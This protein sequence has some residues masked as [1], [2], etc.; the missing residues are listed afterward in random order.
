MSSRIVPLGSAS[1]EA[2][3]WRRVEEAPSAAPPHLHQQ[4]K[5]D[6]SDV[7]HPEDNPDHAS[8]QIDPC[9]PLRAS[10]AALEKQLAL[11]QRA[12]DEREKRAVEQGRLE[13][14]AAGV[15]EGAASVQAEAKT[16][17]EAIKAEAA[18]RVAL[19]AGQAVDLR[20][21]LRQQ[22]EADLVKLAI[23]VARRI[24]RRELAVDP[25]ALLGIVKSAV[26]R[27]AARELLAI[28]VA[29]SDAP[30]VRSRLAGYRL[31]ERVE[32]IED[33]A[34]AWG[35]VVLDT[36]RGHHDASVETQIEEIDRG[37]ADLVGRPA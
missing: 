5:P 19:A 7:N 20:K 31:P 14:H 27:I 4:Q 24:L 1:I 34:L 3:P 21:R 10:I 15:R 33:A 6:R 17:I 11:T 28:R 9:E 26:E 13:G 36:T 25:D 16:A 32:V 12:A 23:A 22:M 8:P 30:R 37:L 29:P 35:S 18:D 2:V